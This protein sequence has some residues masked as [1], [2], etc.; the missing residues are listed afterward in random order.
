MKF[1]WN[2][3][4]V[5]I[6]IMFLLLI[7]P[8][9]GAS[10][11]F[12]KYS[13]KQMHSELEH[14]NQSVLQFHYAT[15]QFELQRMSDLLLEYAVD[16]VIADFDTLVPILS[17][18]EKDFRLNEILQ[19][20][21]QMKAS[22]SYLADV[23]FYIPSSQKIVSAKQGIS[24]IADEQWQG[25]LKTRGNLSGNIVVY[26][27]HLYVMH[28]VPTLLDSSLTPNFIL[29]A[30]ISK[31]EL[32]KQIN[33]IGKG[34]DSGA[35]I[36]FTP[37]AFQLGDEESLQVAT[38]Y[39]PSNPIDY[40]VGVIPYESKD[41]LFYAIVDPNYGFELVSYIQ[42][43]VMLQP[44]RHYYFW[45]LLL[46]MVSFLLVVLFSYGIYLF[47]HRPLFRLVRGFRTV[48][49]GDIALLRDEKRT[50][51]FG[52]LYEQFDKMQ[53]KLYVLIQDNYVQ[54]IR[55]QDAELKHLQSQ[56][57]PHFLYNSLFTIKQMAE[58][59]NIEDIKQFS[60]YLGQYFR[61][62]T[63]DYKKE[64]QLGEEWEHALIYLHIQEIR[65]SHRI[66][67][68]IEPLPKH[69]ASLLVPRIILQPLVENVFK[70][71]L[72]N[73]T[74]GGYLYMNVK[75]HPQA[76][77]ITIADNGGSLTD[78]KLFQLQN[79]LRNITTTGIQGEITGLMNV[80]QRL[81]MY[82]GITYGLT[83]ERSSLGG[84]KIVVSL[85][86]QNKEGE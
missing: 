7:I 64:M 36:Q 76:L 49:R 35:F 52:Y 4:F 2:S 47:I 23:R 56:I 59:E 70:H 26:E 8:L 80:H 18:Y 82:F 24:T 30:E 27:N 77:T 32:L 44:I 11:W 71:G 74:S 41:T 37:F 25:L 29:V 34:T 22:S 63:R 84:L 28:A 10:I 45:M 67:M 46:T 85:P 31:K 14:S 33:L 38:H 66:A 58:L 55:M 83:L 57:A 68:D 16:S 3:M 50:D 12:T 40:K 73:I 19:K 54:R 9:Y 81:Q 43:Q 79:Q 39:Q 13:S 1:R 48:E 72:A 86:L 51:E 61:F 15:L 5:K 60:D 17:N 75:A 69:Y 53:K 6:L 78:T 21:K 65:F 42:K 62:M 20:M